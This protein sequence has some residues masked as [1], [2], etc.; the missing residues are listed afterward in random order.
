MAFQKQPSVGCSQWDQT[1]GKPGE[2][3]DLVSSDKKCCEGVTG[4]EGSLRTERSAVRVMG[5]Q[6]AQLA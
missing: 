1:V 4:V 6:P 3:N 2:T 5:K